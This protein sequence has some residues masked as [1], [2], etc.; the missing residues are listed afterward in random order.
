MTNDKIPPVRPV[1]DISGLP[2]SPIVEKLSVS[3][4]D[5][6]DV[7]YRG[8]DRLGKGED[9]VVLSVGDPDFKTPEPII[10]RAIDSLQNK[11]NGYVAPGGIDELVDVI[12]KVETDRLGYA[13]DKDQIVVCQGAQMALFSIMRCLLADGDEVIVPEPA[14]VTFHGTIVANGAEMIPVPMIQNDTHGFRLDL[15]AIKGAITENTRILLLNFPHNP[16]GALMTAQDIE[17]VAKIVEDNN[18][19]LISDEVYADLVYEG[20]HISPLTIERIRKRTIAIR[21]LSKSHAMT[22]WRVGW[23]LCPHGLADHMRNLMNCMLFGGSAFIQEA[24]ATAL[25]GDIQEVAQMKEAYI[26]R[27]NIVVEMIDRIPGVNAVKPDSGVF[28]VVDIKSTGMSGIEFANRFLDEQGVAVLPGE[29]FGSVLNGYVRMSL[30]AEEAKLA[31]GMTRLASF[32]AGLD[33]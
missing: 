31:E 5:A 26:Q 12:A 9:I 10:N 24:A 33:T 21:S 19:W 25:T 8:L 16:T 32:M 23:A 20:E 3:G 29:V 28:C 13:V 14:Y 18:L 30:C 6:W 2:F 7:H 22:G 11:V 1:D 15:D 17:E 4:S 27:R